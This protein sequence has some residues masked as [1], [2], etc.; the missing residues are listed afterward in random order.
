MISNEDAIDAI[1]YLAICT[2]H[3]EVW[4]ADTNGSIMQ[5]RLQP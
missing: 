3:P 2:A 1:T 4:R 5:K